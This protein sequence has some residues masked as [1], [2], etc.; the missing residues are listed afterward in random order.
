MSLIQELVPSPLRASDS[1]Q[2]LT[3]PASPLVIRE[4]PVVLLG[5]DAVPSAMEVTLHYQRVHVEGLPDVLPE[6]IELD[7]SGLRSGGSL[8]V[9]QM[10]LPE[11]CEVIGVWF[12][13]PVVTVAP[14]V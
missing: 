13:N 7:V 9:D 14:R 2:L 10:P 11:S 6:Q 3:E 5:D 1:P 12:A 8:R 4:L